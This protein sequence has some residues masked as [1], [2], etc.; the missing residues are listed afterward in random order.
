MENSNACKIA[1]PDFFFQN[2]THV[3]ISG[4]LPVQHILVSVG[5]VRASSQMCEM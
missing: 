4:N 3:I 5:T 1:T 2:F